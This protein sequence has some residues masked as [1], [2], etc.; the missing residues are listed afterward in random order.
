MDDVAGNW[1]HA[2]EEAL[3][4]YRELT[5]PKRIAENA[6][7]SYQGTGEQGQFTLGYCGE[8]YVV[9]YPE[10]SIH[11]AS[12]EGKVPTSVK[13]CILL[14]MAQAVP[15]PEREDWKTFKDLPQGY[16]HWAPFVVEAL[17]PL[18]E[19]FGSDL[20][21]FKLAGESLGGIPVAMGD[22]GFRFQV[23]PRIGLQVIVWAGDK[24]F[25][26]KANILFNGNSVMQADTATLYMLGI[27]LAR[28]L[29]CRAGKL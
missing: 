17:D 20:E 5:R 15:L 14:Y 28:R 2:Y 3:K 26:P 9:T 8:D 18:V 7:A 1:S 24:E 22:L 23:L 4:R 16:H 25:S 21:A 19:G 12:G 11:P 10:G 13:I 27:D 29:L 6:G